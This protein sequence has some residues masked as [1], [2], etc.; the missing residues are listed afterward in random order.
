MATP[1]MVLPSS[2]HCSE[3]KGFGA[4]TRCASVPPPTGSCSRTALTSGGTRRAAPAPRGPRKASPRRAQAVAHAHAETA[5]APD[6]EQRL[7]VGNLQV[8][9]ARITHSCNAHRIKGTEE[10]ARAFELLRIGRP[11]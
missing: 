1:E 10:R 4:I 7:V 6:L 9:A 11:R 8:V 2:I 5:L 3:T